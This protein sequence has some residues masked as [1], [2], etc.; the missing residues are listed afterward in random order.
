MKFPIS[1]E[2]LQTFSQEEENEEIKKEQI[3]KLINTDLDV[4]RKAFNMHMM[5]DSLKLY[6][7]KKFEYR[8]DTN[9][10]L[11]RVGSTIS[12]YE[13]LSILIEKIKELFIGCDFVISPLPLQYIIIDWS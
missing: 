13:Y 2:S 4:F 8:F 10:S 12:Q 3:E 6:K 1:R 9:N 5:S 7:Q 11:R